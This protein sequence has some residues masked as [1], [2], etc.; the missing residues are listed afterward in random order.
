M[1]RDDAQMKLRMPESLREAIREAAERS[2][3]SM[4]AEIVMRLE[5]SLSAIPDLTPDIGSRNETPVNL[6]RTRTFMKAAKEF[7][8]FIED[9]SAADE[10]IITIRKAKKPAPS[11]DGTAK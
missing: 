11:D 9:E 6:G 3:R 10:V 1:S 7:A 5:Q 8:T 4:N 2:G